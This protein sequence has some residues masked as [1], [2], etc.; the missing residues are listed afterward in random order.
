MNSFQDKACS[1]GHVGPRRNNGN[2]IQCEKERYHTDPKRKEY[3]KDK[4]ANRRA[5]IKADPIKHAEQK[6]YMKAYSKA[7]RA[8][9]SEQ[10]RDLYRRDN[11]KIRL[12]RKGI[13]PT[14]EVLDYIQNH[15]GTCD[16][17]G[18]PPDDRWKEFAFDHCHTTGVFRGLL[19]GRCNKAIG[20][21]LDKPEL[22][23]LA[24][25]YVRHYQ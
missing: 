1:R 6:E 2:C 9:L 20:L 11:I 18:S 8:K 22:M 10:S 25:S 21:F 4:Q 16:L 7:N 19:C 12:Q 23:E 5:A 14:P 15:K 17:C 24:A 3:V 13:K